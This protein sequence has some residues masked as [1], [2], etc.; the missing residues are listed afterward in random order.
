MSQSKNDAVEQEVTRRAA[1]EMAAADA[2]T[3][4]ELRAFVR[5]LEYTRLSDEA[6]RN[7]EALFRLA[8]V[9][10]ADQGNAYLASS[11]GLC[12]DIR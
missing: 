1:E 4:E 9:C 6:V 3:L 5:S 2:Q 10:A 7:M 8:E 12:V 11:Q